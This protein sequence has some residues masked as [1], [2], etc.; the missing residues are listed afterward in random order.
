MLCLRD[1]GSFLAWI[2]TGKDEQKVLGMFECENILSLITSSAEDELTETLHDIL[3][4]SGFPS[5]PTIITLPGTLVEINCYKETQFVDR[6]EGND[7]LSDLI[8]KNIERER[9]GEWTA[10]L[11]QAAERRGGIYASGAAIPT[12]WLTTILASCK[13]AG[14]DVF[15]IEPETLSIFRNHVKREAEG[16]LIDFHGS[17]VIMTGFFPAKGIIS[18]S[19]ENL[20]S[21]LGIQNAVSLFEDAAT[22]IFGPLDFKRVPILLYGTVTS[23]LIRSLQDTSLSDR[24]RTLSIASTVKCSKGVRFLPETIASAGGAL[25]GLDE[26]PDIFGRKV[27]FVPAEIQEQQRHKLRQH[28]ILKILRTVCAMLAVVLVVEGAAIAYSRFTHDRVVPPE[29][30]KQYDEAVAETARWKQRS[31]INQKAAIEDRELIKLVDTLAFIR[32]DG[33]KL[34][35]LEINDQGSVTLEGH[36]SDPG[37]FNLYVSR[38]TNEKNY[39]QSA[40][41]DRIG[42]VGQ[43]PTKTFIIQAKTLR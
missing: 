27:N 30:Q 11:I 40:Q 9:E 42:T 43:G 35:R 17:Q 18:F 22:E 28:K 26:E 29:I 24:L 14:V 36:G 37:N 21:V 12:A 13:A 7:H 3:Q 33:V 8:K 16:I 32:P 20:Y 25:D 5:R 15:R 1:T 39:F 23:E 38:I 2:K 34:T 31:E 6:D 4:Q 41:L 19:F 10:R